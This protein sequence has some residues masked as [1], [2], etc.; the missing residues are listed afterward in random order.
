MENN[1]TDSHHKLKILIA[2]D[3]PINCEYLKL[4]LDKSHFD[5]DITFAKSGK[6]ALE[7]YEKVPDIDF[8]FMDLK[9]PT[10]DGFEATK[11][12][13]KLRPDLPIVAQTAFTSQEDRNRALDAGRSDFLTKSTYMPVIEEVLNKFLRN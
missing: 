13:K 12:I 4:I 5:L 11:R 8:V 3:E 9:M 7:L 10:M 2:E 1:V 6:E